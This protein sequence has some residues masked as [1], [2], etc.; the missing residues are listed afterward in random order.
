M[1]TLS[2][3][4]TRRGELNPPS[5][6]FAPDAFPEAKSSQTGVPV[7]YVPEPKSTESSSLIGPRPHMPA[8]TE[9]LTEVNSPALV[10]ELK[11]NKDAQAAISQIKNRNY[12]QKISEYTGDILLVGINYNK[13]T[14]HHE[15]EIE[16]WR[17]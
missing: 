9:H 4:T 7:R 5:I 6:R 15:C 1:G 14:K 2:N 13:N 3:V 11:Y 17:L 16:R 10:V 8:H 12:P